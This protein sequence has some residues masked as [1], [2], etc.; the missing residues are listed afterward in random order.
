MRIEKVNELIG[1]E[2]SK[3]ILEEFEFGEGIMVTVMRVEASSKLE[4]A[5]VW[6]SVFPEGKSGQVLAKLNKN[7]GSIQK[8]LNKKISLRFV[9]KI[10]FKLDTS[11]AYAQSIDE[12][13]FDIKQNEH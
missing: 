5:N 3:I 1:Q 12:L 13:L 6:V 2:V 9:P 4:T 11:E 10:F 7:I 8:R